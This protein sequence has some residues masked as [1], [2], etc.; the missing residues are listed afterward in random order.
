MELSLEL[1]K[2]DRSFIYK[3]YV[4]ERINKQYMSLL[5][6]EIIATDGLDDF[7]SVPEEIYKNDPN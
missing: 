4:V 6:K 3:A 2:K 1:R 7:L 5:V